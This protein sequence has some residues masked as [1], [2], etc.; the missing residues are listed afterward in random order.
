MG[1]KP[2]FWPGRKSMVF[3]VRNRQFP[4][5]HSLA[6]TIGAPRDFHR[7]VVDCPSIFSRMPIASA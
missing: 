6:G 5:F 4:G 2:L 3:E 1:G 7:G